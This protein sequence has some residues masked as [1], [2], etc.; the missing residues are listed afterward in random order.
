MSNPD[1]VG[2]PDMEELKRVIFSKSALVIVS[3]GD[4]PCP[5]G[6]YSFPV[7]NTWYCR[8]LSIVLLHDWMRTYMHTYNVHELLR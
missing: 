8:E 5:S 6:R 1:D 4:N 7:E 3:G 2:T